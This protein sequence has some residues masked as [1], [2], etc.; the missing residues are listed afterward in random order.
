MN[1]H[2]YRFQGTLVR[3][4]YPGKPSRSQARMMPIETENDFDVFAN[5]PA[6]DAPILLSFA[7]HH[8]M[9]A[10]IVEN[11]QQLWPE[12]LSILLRISMPAGMRLP[13]ALL[14]SNVLMVQ[15]VEQELAKQLAHHRHLLVIEDRFA[16]FQIE[17]GNNQINLCLF[18]DD[19]D[20]QSQFEQ[21]LAPL[22]ERGI[23]AQVA[24][25]L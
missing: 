20:Q 24:E 22:A 5:L 18:S 17:R 7:E 25:A 6:T 21:L 14:T 16:R 3:I 11:A 19:D 9:L 15:E 10:E 8:Q 1:K 13:S 2:N 4:P 23:E 12:G